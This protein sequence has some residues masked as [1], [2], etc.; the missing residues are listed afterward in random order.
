MTIRSKLCAL[1]I[2]ALMSGCWATT[3]ASAGTIQ[4]RTLRL[5]ARVAADNIEILAFEVDANGNPSNISV[6]SAKSGTDG[7]Y[8]LDV[9]SAN[10]VEIDFFQNGDLEAKLQRVSGRIAIAGLDIVIPAAARA[11]LPAPQVV[12]C[13]VPCRPRFFRCR[14]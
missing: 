12:P 9:T 5:D 14:R 11:P 13:Y 6:G 4:G 1:S 8:R 2:A 7:R 10:P 3:H